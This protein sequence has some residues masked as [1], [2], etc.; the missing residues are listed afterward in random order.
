MDNW[1]EQKNF[2]CCG[3][4]DTGR[5]PLASEL[6]KQVFKYFDRLQKLDND[7]SECLVRHAFHEQKHLQLK[8][9]SRISNVR[10]LAQNR[11]EV[12][13]YYP[14]QT[15]SQIKKEFETIWSEERHLNC[16][17]IFYNS[18]KDKFGKELYLD[19]TME[20]KDLNH[21]SQ[22]RTSSHK[23]NI[24][25]GR[26]GQ[27]G[28]SISNRICKHCSTEDSEIIDSLCVLPFYDPIIEDEEHVLNDCPLY[29]DIRTKMKIETR[30]KLTTRSGIKIA[31]CDVHQ[32]REAARFL[33]KC[34]KRR[35]PEK[36]NKRKEQESV[37]NPL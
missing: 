9:Y 19:I 32:I 30:E 11:A 22:I 23:Y 25:T 21:I 14:S 34:H 13:I 29:E 26:Y 36:L 12:P 15:R 24:E 6:S 3:M 27:K 10:E 2:K 1:S 7:N 18:I 4:G 16:K 8:W 35:F 37:R 5:Y 20:Y 17:L 28:L 33:R 31:F